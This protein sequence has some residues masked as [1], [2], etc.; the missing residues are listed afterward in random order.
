MR[1]KDQGPVA[2]EKDGTD[3]V[4]W[5]LAGSSSEV[6]APEDNGV[7]SREDSYKGDAEEDGSG[8]GSGSGG[9]GPPPIILHGASVN[10]HYCAADC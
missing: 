3:Y 1:E 5:R 7:E 6:R 4:G 8:G 2:T 10:V 9:D